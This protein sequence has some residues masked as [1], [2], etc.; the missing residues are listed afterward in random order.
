MPHP[1]MK[2]KN[3]EVIVRANGIEYKGILKEVTEDSVNLKRMLGWVEIPIDKISSIR[4]ADE[5]KEG[6]SKTKSVNPSY[7]DADIEKK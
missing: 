1:I 3:K 6:F 4:A 7:F 2:Y 5:G